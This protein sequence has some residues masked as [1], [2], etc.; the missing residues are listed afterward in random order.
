MNKFWKIKAMADGE[1]EILLYEF[2]GEDFFGQG[3]GA[4]QFHDELK[5]LGDIS[6]IIV[7]INS[8]GGDVFDGNTIYNILKA[9]KAQVEVHIDG[10]AASIASVIAMAGD[11]II[12]PENAMMMIHNPWGFAVGDAAEMRKMADALDK[13]RESI[14]VS[15]RAQTDLDEKKLFEMMDEETWMTAA[16]AVELGFA[17]EMIESVKAAASFKMDYFK[18]VPLALKDP[19]ELRDPQPT[20]NE[21][22]KRVAA[23]RRRTLELLA[24]EI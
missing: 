4:K 2:I 10:I 21:E 15:Y 3:M 14:V 11:K 1:A 17:D 8:P 23:S 16:D 20:A 6:K 22:L 12:M 5:A 19:L 24:A 9:H 7:R 18:N 13:I